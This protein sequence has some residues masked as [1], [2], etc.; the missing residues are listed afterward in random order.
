MVEKPELKRRNVFKTHDPAKHVFHV[1]LGLT[2]ST[3]SKEQHR[4]QHPFLLEAGERILGS[5]VVNGS[6][7][8]KA[9]FRLGFP[10]LLVIQIFW[11][12]FWRLISI[13]NRVK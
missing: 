3:D 5:P 10:C 4:E 12:L 2:V 13:D 8:F 7:L 1:S 9:K 6:L 11:F